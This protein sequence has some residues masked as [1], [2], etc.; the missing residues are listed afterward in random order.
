AGYQAPRL[1]GTQSNGVLDV[2]VHLEGLIDV[3]KEKARLQREIDKA[4]KDK[5]GLE[6]RFANEDFVKKA[7]PEVVA[8][9]RATMAA[10]DE[11]MTRLGAALVRLG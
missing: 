11:K 8:E 1:S 7:P 2:V 4:S 5:A 3:D 6:K 10:L 9:G